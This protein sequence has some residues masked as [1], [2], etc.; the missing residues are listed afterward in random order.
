MK[1]YK[2]FI[3]EVKIGDSEVERLWISHNGELINVFDW[4]NYH[5][6]TFIKYMEK[7]YPEMIGQYDN[8]ENLNEV[9]IKNIALELG[10]IWITSITRENNN[11]LVIEVDEPKKDAVISLKKYM[12]NNP[13]EKYEVMWKRNNM[14]TF[15]TPREVVSAII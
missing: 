2:Q 6:E 11:Q 15:R 1:T 13:H 7:Y 5:D 14:K 8:L 12:E 10:W 4:G 3:L 9:Y